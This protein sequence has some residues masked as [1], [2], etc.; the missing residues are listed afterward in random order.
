MR[1]RDVAHIVGASFVD[2]DSFRPAGKQRLCMPEKMKLGDREVYVREEQ[3]EIAREEWNEYRLLDG[4]RVRVKT[5]VFR[6]FRI[7]D[8]SNTPQFT[9]EGD[10]ELIVRHNT[11][12]V[13][14]DRV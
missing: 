12:V 4:G 5:S 7:V 6:I 3:F 14:I 9:A 8:E 2:Y 13:A 1:L 10:P 11:Q